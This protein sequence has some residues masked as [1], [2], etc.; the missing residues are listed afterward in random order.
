MPFTA[1][2]AVAMDPPA[3][4]RDQVWMPARFTWTNEGEAVGFIP[5]RYPGSTE[6]GDPALL[7]ARRTEWTERGDWSLPLGQRML[8][9]DTVETALMDVRKLRFHTAAAAA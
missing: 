6:T 7:L 1:L 9:T 4:L 3:D 5:T 2:S 8:V